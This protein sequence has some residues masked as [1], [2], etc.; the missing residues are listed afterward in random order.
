MFDGR[1]C[2]TPHV[3]VVLGFLGVQDLSFIA[4]R[5]TMFVAPD[6]A[7]AAMQTAK[8]EAMRLAQDWSTSWG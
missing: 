6:I 1:D 3:R 5:P 2:L 8:E 4:V 7:S